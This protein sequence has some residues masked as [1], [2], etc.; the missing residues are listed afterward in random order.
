RHVLDDGVIAG[1]EVTTRSREGVN[2]EDHT[3]R[4]FDHVHVVYTEFGSMLVQTPRAH[5]L[6]PVDPVI[7]EE[8]LHLG[9]SA[10]EDIPEPQELSADYVLEPESDTFLE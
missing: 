4:G 7:E 2:S 10:L 1:S 8:E 3:V 5:Q 9:D 6:L